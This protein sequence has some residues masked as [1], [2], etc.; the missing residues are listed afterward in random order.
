MITSGW[1]RYYLD[2]VPD[3]ACKVVEA[4]GNE[5]GGPAQP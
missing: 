4:G 3:R 5:K 1:F 2:N